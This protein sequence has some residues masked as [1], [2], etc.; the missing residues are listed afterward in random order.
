MVQEWKCKDFK[1]KNKCNF[2]YVFTEIMTT[3]TKTKKKL[4]I[5]IVTKHNE[6]KGL[7]CRVWECADMEEDICSIYFHR[8]I[9]KL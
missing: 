3:S 2:N 7:E 8:T 1:T 6:A 4:L 9:G 5:D